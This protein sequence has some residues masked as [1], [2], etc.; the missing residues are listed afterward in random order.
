MVLIDGEHR[1]RRLD[2]KRSNTTL[3]S[4]R[5]SSSEP[6]SIME[7]SLQQEDTQSPN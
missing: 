7:P 5:P 1:S 3:E 2:E 6:Y 4:Y